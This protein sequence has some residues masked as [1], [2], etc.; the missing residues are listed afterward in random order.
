MG[1]LMQRIQQVSNLTD[2]LVDA[3]K[4]LLG[5]NHNTG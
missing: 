4:H 5:L 3:R 1:E 2:R